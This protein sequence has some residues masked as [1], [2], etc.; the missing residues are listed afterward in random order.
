[1][2]RW[3]RSRFPTFGRY[4]SLTK[5]VLMFI[6]IQV[7][8]L[9]CSV[10]GSAAGVISPYMTKLTFDLAYPNRDFMLLVMLSAIGLVLMLFSTVSG[11]I[12]QYLQL[13]ASQNASFVLR[14]DLIKHLY[15]LPLSFFHSRSTGEHLYRLNS[16]AGGTAAFLGGIVPNLLSP[17]VSIVFPLGAVV[18]LDWRFAIVAAAVAP[19]FALHS[20]Y[21]GSRQ[22]DLARET[23]METQRVSSESTDRITQIKLV[24]S[25][26]CERREIKEYLSNQIKLMRLGY[27]QYWLGLK[28]TTASSV[29][30]TVLQTGLSLYLGYQVVSGR[31][32]IG[33]LVALSMYF[34][35]LVGAV[36]G[37]AGL[38]QGLL[39]QLVPVDRL[40]DVFEISGTITE[41]PGAVRPGKLS[42]SISFHDVGFSYNEETTVLDGLDMTVLPGQMVAI[43]GPSGAGKSTILNLILRLYDPQSGS[44]RVDGHDIRDLKL[45]PYRD[46]IGVALQETFLFNTTIR[47]NIRYGDPRST[48]D[49]IAEA[50]MMSDAHGF[51]T[52]LPDGYDTIVGEAGCNLSMGQRQRIGIARALLRKPKLLILDEATASLSTASEA[53]IL[54]N[55]RPSGDERT[56]IAITH[57]LAAIHRVD[58]IFVVQDGRIMERGTHDQLLGHH[59]LYRT[60]WDCQFGTGDQIRGD[61]QSTAFDSP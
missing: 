60:L 4:R 16:D 21:F 59:G 3:L 30:N 12:Q 32:T 34:M 27:R 54:T 9:I 45:S 49:E 53:A 40:L 8:M 15:K 28:S 2:K 13:Y 5:Y 24:K 46:Q 18:L 36:K 39:S 14:A 26:G 31:M 37:V 22:R 57:R 48:D 35:Q 56:V 43:V 25:F 41:K 19:A 7:G 23:A 1:M 33:T 55:V 51:I 6:D 42:G 52:D 61:D 20:R 17:F 58:C 11:A 47:E 38:Y 29:L 10:L 44:I 50:S